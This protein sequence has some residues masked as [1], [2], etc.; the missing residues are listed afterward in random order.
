[1]G[2]LQAV[3]VESRPGFPGKSWCTSLLRLFCRRSASPSL[4]AHSYR[5]TV[6][7]TERALTPCSGGRV[8]SLEERLLKSS[9]RWNEVEGHVDP[10]TLSA[11]P[12]SAQ[13]WDSPHC[14]EW[15]VL[16]RLYVHTCTRPLTSCS[17]CPGVHLEDSTADMH[18]RNVRPAFPVLLQNPCLSFSFGL[19]L[20]DF[21][22]LSTH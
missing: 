8:E 10:E 19:E 6:V 22:K 16:P 12:R 1:M 11:E 13:P 3:M 4:N 21:P 7:A 14:T 9:E 15:Y 20:Q 18:W 5:G 2:G 17:Q